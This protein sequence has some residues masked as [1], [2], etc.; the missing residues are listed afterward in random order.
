MHKYEEI[1]VLLR[2]LHA[3]LLIQSDSLEVLSH[4]AFTVRETGSG[5]FCSSR[6]PEGCN[7]TKP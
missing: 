3:P 2:F 6:G 1:V 5:L 4:T 7:Y